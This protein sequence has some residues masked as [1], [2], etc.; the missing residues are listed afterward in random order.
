MQKIQML[1]LCLMNIEGATS[2]VA[3]STSDTSGLSGFRRYPASL[4]T[5]TFSSSLVFFE[6]MNGF[7]E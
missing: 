2:G 5:S 6:T 1:W 4:V 3:S 7:L